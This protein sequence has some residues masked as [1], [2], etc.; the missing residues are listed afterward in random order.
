MEARVGEPGD[1]CRNVDYV[2]PAEP[3]DVVDLPEITVSDV[4]VGEE[5]VSFSVDQIGV[6]VLVRVSYFPNW[7]VSG[8]EGPVPGRPELHGR[9]ADRER[10]DTDLRPVRASTS[11]STA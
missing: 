1:R 2:V 4:D 9:H 11:S 8:A 10:G 6:P 3:I 7:E 5:S